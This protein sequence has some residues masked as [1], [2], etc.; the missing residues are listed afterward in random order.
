MEMMEAIGDLSEKEFLDLAFI[1]Y[2]MGYPEYAIDALQKSD[3]GQRIK[4]KIKERVENWLELSN[5]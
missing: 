1:I 4:R 3:N 2:C 5:G